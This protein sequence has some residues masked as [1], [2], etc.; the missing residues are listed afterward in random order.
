M[1]AEVIHGGQLDAAVEK[2][3][4]E[5]S[6]WLDLSTGINPNCWKIPELEDQLWARLPDA[7][8]YADCASAARKVFGVP[9][10][11]HISLASGSQMHIQNL[12][13]LFKPQPVA[14][15]GFSYQE[16]GICWQREGHEVY[17]T[18]G[19]ESA[20]ATARIVVVVNP[21]NPDG[22]I[23]DRETLAALARRLG[24]KGGLLVVDEAFGE[25]APNASIADQA[26]REGLVV[27]RSLGKF[28]GLAG[29]RLGAA[30]TNAS[31]GQRLDSRL[32]PW[33][34]SGPALKI[35]AT[36][37]ADTKW[38]NRTLNKL[39]VWREE[40]EILLQGNGLRVVGGT[41][42]F[43]LASHDDVAGLAEHL[44]K[45]RILVRQFPGQ[46][47]WLRFGIAGKKSNLNRLGK[48]LGS[49][50]S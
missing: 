31:L 11:A 6:K 9:Q 33:A 1:M 3:G 16:H 20:E 18:D 46:M 10:D 45:K 24:A 30:L 22:R 32:G 26:G 48:A 17:V 39:Q 36:A 28:Y 34:V 14:L 29:V 7:N 12:P 42:L 40:L 25:V 49:F 13:A 23:F 15:V 44:A 2:Y 38:Q 35:G 43:V 37:W 47:K 50:V 27:L 21:N 41:S 5:K 8:L 19:L 4:G